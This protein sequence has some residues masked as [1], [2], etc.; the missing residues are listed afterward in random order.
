MHFPAL[1]N[2]FIDFSPC[3]RNS[4]S[5]AIS[6]EN[7]DT[8]FKSQRKHSF[9]HISH[10]HQQVSPSQACTSSCGW[11]IMGLGPDMNHLC[12]PRAYNSAGLTV[13][14]QYTDA[15]RPTVELHPD[16]ALV[17]CNY[18]GLKMH[19]IGLPYQT[20]QLS[21]AHLQCSQSTCVG[22]QLGRIVEHNE[23]TV[24]CLWF[25]F[26]AAW[27]TGSCSVLPGPNITEG[28]VPHIARSIVSTECVLLLNHHKVK[29][30]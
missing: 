17:N 18:S 6:Q 27:L 7:A 12:I 5:P 15:S 19:L 22:L 26:V 28:T 10:S 24:E 2:T 13:E 1:H 16:K 11:W 25:A 9:L 20:S 14:T 21:L 3:G 30:V 8:S 4:L 23:H 29:K